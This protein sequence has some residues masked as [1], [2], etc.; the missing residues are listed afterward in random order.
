MVASEFI[1]ARLPSELKQRVQ[2]F[3][4]RH[5]LSESAWLKRLVVRELQTSESRELEAREAS[6]LGVLT[7]RRA[8]PAARSG[9]CSVRVYVRL[10]Q[11]DSQLLEARAEAR[12]MRAATYVSVLTRNHLRRVVPLPKDELMVLRRSVTELSGI[13]RNLNQ[14]ARATSEGSRPTGAVREEL[15]A[16]LKVC[17]ALRD[18]TKALLKANLTSW[19]SGCGEDV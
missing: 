2:S 5:S 12:G 19:E 10:R 9:T 18:Q 14:L 17:H 13:G 3:A 1:K 16:M 8:R 7:S 15:R 4:E 6:D 11:D